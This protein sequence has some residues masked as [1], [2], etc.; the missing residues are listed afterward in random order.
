MK[1]TLD[2][3]YIDEFGKWHHADAVVDQLDLECWAVEKVNTMP[4]Y[5]RFGYVAIKKIEMED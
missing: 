1:I 4:N 5:D 3:G 2:I